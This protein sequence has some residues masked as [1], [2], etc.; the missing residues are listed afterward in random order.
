M[1]LFGNYQ[2]N[3]EFTELYGCDSTKACCVLQAN[4]AVT[5]KVKEHEPY[6]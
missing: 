2:I 6:L 3:I 4:T 1:T 5:S